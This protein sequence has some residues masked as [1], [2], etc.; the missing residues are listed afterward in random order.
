MLLNSLSRFRTFEP[1]AV[2]QFGPITGRIQ[3]RTG[4]A[5]S[6]SAGNAFELTLSY[7]GL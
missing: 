3:R 6:T 7:P 1:A 2:E 5:S 4:R